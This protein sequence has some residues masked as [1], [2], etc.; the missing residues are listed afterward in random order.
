MKF[1]D[2]NTLIASWG[3]NAPVRGQMLTGILM[4]ETM[5]KFSSGGGGLQ[6]CSEDVRTAEVVFV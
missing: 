4:T 5:L 1:P 2:A 3:L 6:L